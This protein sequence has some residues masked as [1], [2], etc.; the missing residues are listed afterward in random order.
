MLQAEYI[1][2]MHNN[3]LVLK[4]ME[5]QV[6][7][8]GTRMLLNNLIP[9]LLKTE[10]R[11]IDRMDLFYY[12][13]TYKK[14]VAAFCENKSI[15]YKELKNILTNILEI[16]ENS[17][18]FLLTENNFIIEPSYVFIDSTSQDIEL[19]YLAGRDE[20][21]REQLSRFMEYLMNKVD[22]KD[23]A[24]VVLIYAIYKE[25]KEN[26]CTFEKLKKTLNKKN[27]E[28]NVKKIIVVN[29]EHADT[30]K[31]VKTGEANGFSKF[32][33][34]KHDVQDKK[35]NKNLS[36]PDKT[37][38]NKLNKRT[39]KQRNQSDKQRNQSDKQKN[40][41]DIQKN[42]SDIQKKNTVQDKK[43]KINQKAPY[44]NDRNEKLQNQ[45]SNNSNSISPF[46]NLRFRFQE[47]INKWLGKVNPIPESSWNTKT[48]LEEIESEKEILYFGHKT[49]ILAGFSV[50]AGIILFLV[51][52]QL[53]LLQN[54]FGTHID[55]VKLLSCII[56]IGCAEAYI[57][58]KLFDPRHKLTGIKTDVEYIESGQEVYNT[59]VSGNFN[60]NRNPEKPESFVQQQELQHDQELDNRN[61][62]ETR[63][64]WAEDN[65]A[66]EKTEILAEILPLVSYKLINVRDENITE[67]PVDQFPF[68]IG[69]LN[70]GVN[71]IIEDTS[72][73]R[74]HARLTREGE[75]IFLTD[76]NS[77]NGT[78]LNGIKL[79]E[80][81]PYL[82]SDKDKIS[83]SQAKYTWTVYKEII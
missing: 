10:L 45:A 3:Y 75:D 48:H 16:I 29:E 38:K 7:A 40:Q 35:D 71:L 77:T 47:F 80:N 69:K 32:N 26:D 58:I 36:V 31:F 24:A 49:Y 22:Y 65:S 8:Y 21:I 53:K 15:N 46:L 83:F 5:G 41:S 17:G 66:Q 6:S 23:E 14:S 76:L 56:M 44:R 60:M 51:V 37:E 52:L 39:G 73:S 25:S 27:N 81:K 43:N 74:R 62:D 54:S 68:F 78:F 19:C 30:S 82:I 34:V 64:I 42:Q 12:D 67:I 59:S 9:G 55:M 18:E 33:E 11:C 20:N 28:P 63:I 4:G 2:D 13:I 1:R 79:L 61:Q 50:M 72:V 70:R 57:I